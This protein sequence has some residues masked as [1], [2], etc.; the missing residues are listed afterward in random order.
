LLFTILF[1][2]CQKDITDSQTSLKEVTTPSN[3][4]LSVSEANAMAASPNGTISREVTFGPATTNFKNTCLENIRF[5]GNIEEK[6]HRSTDAQGNVHYVRSFNAK[7][8]TGTGVTSLMSYSVVGGNE[9]FSIKKNPV[10]GAVYPNIGASINNSDVL[11]HQ[12]TLVF[13]RSDGQRVI[14]RHSI[15]VTPNG[16]VKNEWTCAGRKG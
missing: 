5:G 13:V 3:T 9:M 4:S 1:S 12:G 11:I 16:T 15:V 8:M 14:A 2:A 7:G 6:I 10:M